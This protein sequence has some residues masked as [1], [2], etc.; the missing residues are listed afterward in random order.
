MWKLRWRV[1]SYNLAF[2]LPSTSGRLFLPSFRCQRSSL[3]IKLSVVSDSFSK[4]AIVLPSLL[5]VLKGQTWCSEDNESPRGL[6]TGQIDEL[7]DLLVNLEIGLVFT[8]RHVV[9]VVFNL[10]RCCASRR[11]ITSVEFK[12]AERQVVASVVIRVAKLEIVAESR[13]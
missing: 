13:T 12:F 4:F 3:S 10:P 1:L 7:R 8:V 11:P 6:C 5:I 2:R 9:A